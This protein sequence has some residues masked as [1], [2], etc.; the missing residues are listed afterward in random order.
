MD[1]GKV[2]SA[3]SRGWAA[4]AGFEAGMSGS[5]VMLL[6]LGLASVWYRHSVWHAANVMA[7][8][9]YGDSVI[10]PGFT[11]HTLSGLAVYLILYSLFGALF[12][13]TMYGSNWSRLRLALL[14]MLAA[15]AWYYL[16]FGLV[17]PRVNPLVQIYTHDRPMFWGHL[18]YG[19][20]LGRFPIYLSRLTAAPAVPGPPTVEAPAALEAAAEESSRV[21]E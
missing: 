8:T 6:C 4:L 16:W 11:R 2:A 14:G 7:S 3:D 19:A 13:A 21:P 15:V 20:M 17:W 1:A 12:G 18:L 9:F 5:L 10:G